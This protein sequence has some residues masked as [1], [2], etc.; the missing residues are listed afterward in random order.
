MNGTERSRT[1]LFRNTCHQLLYHNAKGL[2]KRVEWVNMRAACAKLIM[3]VENQRD[4][5][6]VA[7]GHLKRLEALGDFIPAQLW[8]RGIRLIHDRTTTSYS[9]PV[10]RRALASKRCDKSLIIITADFKNF[11]VLLGSMVE[12]DRD[13]APHSHDADWY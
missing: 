2:G 6:V 5:L 1:W 9:K 11:A 13:H 7:V 8:I 4:V 12:E 3:N 10:E